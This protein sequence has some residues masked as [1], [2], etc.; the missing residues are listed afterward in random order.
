M[1][2]L[3]GSGGYVVDTFQHF[4]ALEISAI[5]PTESVLGHSVVP[6]FAGLKPKLVEDE[7]EGLDKP[8]MRRGRQA[9]SH[10]VLGRGEHIEP[11]ESVASTAD[12][13]GL[14]G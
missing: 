5:E 6:T 9:S 2:D 8:W 3:G 7:D 11:L 13:A 14:L 1:L 10:G 4:D 12:C